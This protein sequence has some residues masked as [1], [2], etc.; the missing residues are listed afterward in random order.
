MNEVIILAMGDSSARTELKLLLQEMNLNHVYEVM[1]GPQAIRDTVILK[2]ELI[3]AD[4]TLAY[5]NGYQFCRFVRY[6]LHLATPLILLISSQQKPDQYWG[7]SCG[8][9]YCLPKPVNTQAIMGMVSELLAE[10]RCQRFFFESHIIGQHTSDLDILKMAN[11]L[12]DRHLFQEKLLAELKSMSRQVESVRDLVS[13]LMTVIHS[14]FPYRSA[15]MLLSYEAKA[16]LLALPMEEVGQH[17][18]DSLRAC[19]ISHVKKEE[20]LSFSVDDIPFTVLGSMAPK[21]EV[22]S[23]EYHSGDISIFFGENLQSILCYIAFDGLRLETFPKEEIRTFHRIMDQAMETIEEKIIFGKSINFSIIDFV[24]RGEINRSFFLKLLAQSM[25]QAR[26]LQEPLSLLMLDLEN[27]P[28]LL[29]PLRKKST[30][31]LQ[32]KICQSLLHT[33]RKMDIVA[34]IRQDKFAIVVTRAS[35]E[36][37][38]SVYRRVKK[39]LE[40]LSLPHE[41]LQVRGSLW[42]YEVS[43]GGDAEEFLRVACSQA[44]SPSGTS[45]HRPPSQELE[46]S[47][48]N[49]SSCEE[50]VITA[51]AEN[52]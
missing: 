48:D 32:Q 10:K 5:V 6:G 28:Q 12:L 19:L 51:E 3:I 29:E 27:Y 45:P 41:H 46:S 37:A 23:K 50:S 30:F 52:V 2:P 38:R 18:L 21:G 8:A 26:R 22:D 20:E 42:P 43:Y 36:Q 9:D 33:V 14:L 34:R 35:R 16:E 40:E 15:A 1:H 31:H 4:D 49:P 17:R 11:D 7:T 47:P 44:S 24:S 13:V 25:E 39:C